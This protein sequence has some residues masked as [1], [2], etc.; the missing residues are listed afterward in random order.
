M[1]STPML[2]PVAE[3]EQMIAQQVRAWEVLDPHTLEAMREIPRERFVAA[4]W[5]SLAYADCALPLPLGK[6]MLTPMLVGRIVQSLE[7]RPGEQVLEIGTG[8]GYLSACLAALGAR[9]QS[10][11]LHE[12]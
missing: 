10:L 4:A 11:E 5:Q 12:E 3:R 1:V 6:H 7:I 9:V 8:S 2:K